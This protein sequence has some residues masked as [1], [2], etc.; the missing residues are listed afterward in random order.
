MTATGSDDGDSECAFAALVFV[1]SLVIF[2]AVRRTNYRG[3]D[4]QGALE[5]SGHGGVIRGVATASPQS[6]PSEPGVRTRR[7]ECH[8]PVRSEACVIRRNIST[9]T[10]STVVSESAETTAIESTGSIDGKSI[11]PAVLAS[12]GSV[13]LALYFY[14]VS[15]DKQRGQFVGLWPVTILAIAS[16]FKLEEI[17]QL[18]SG[19]AE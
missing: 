16:Y 3:P 19:D 11:T 12:V 18:L 13:A 6:D 7:P 14:Y 1:V 10:H 5:D 4:R 8:Q 2:V 15:G 17:R 9:K